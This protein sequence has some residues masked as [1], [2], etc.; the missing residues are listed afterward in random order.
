M[1]QLLS[2]VLERV[3]GPL[4]RGLESQVEPS[5][6]GDPAGDPDE[7]AV[8]GAGSRGSVEEPAPPPF[9]PQNSLQAQLFGS[10]QQRSSIEATAAV[11]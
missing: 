2:G 10:P 8:G 7:C 9:D 11:A 1:V 6:S 3:E 4:P 5:R